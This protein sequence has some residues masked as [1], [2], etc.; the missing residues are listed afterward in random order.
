[1]DECLLT[2]VGIDAQKMTNVEKKTW[3]DEKNMVDE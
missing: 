3:K 2:F 1:M